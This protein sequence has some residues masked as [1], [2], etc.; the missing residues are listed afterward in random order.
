[1]RV[2]YFA[3]DLSDASVAK[4]IR[5]LRLGG[6]TVSVIG[7]RRT[8]APILEI[9]GIAAVDLG[10][11]FDGRLV[12]RCKMVIHR[13]AWPKALI[14]CISTADVVVARNLEMLTI[15][16]AA[17]RKARSRA[18]LVYECLDV[19]NIML[20]SGLPSRLLRRWESSLLQRAS[21]LVI[22]SEG[23]LNHYFHPMAYQLPQVLVVENKRILPG[24][25]GP[26]PERRR[27]PGQPPWR[28]GWFGILRCATSFQLLLE[29]ATTHPT[30][31]DIELRGRPAQDVQTLIARH[32]PLGNMRFGGPYAPSD[33]EV[34][35]QG[36]DFVWAID[37]YQAGQNSEWLLPNRIYEGSFYNVPAIALRNTE[38]ARWLQRRTAGMNV[39]DPG[40]DL[41]Q[42][43]KTLSTA[44]YDDMQ[45]AVADIPLSDLVHSA[46]ECRALI[47][48]ML[49]A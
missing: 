7:F 29:L 36:C 1:M 32:L 20:G 5:M 44:R 39:A 45:R 48:R 6:A 28:I 9:E 34:I 14:P 43:L 46:D 37:Y 2:T 47:N 31:V 27:R 11:T 13:S 33:L 38:T 23:F 24:I 40:S 22:S 35:Y 3:H 18:S 19:H 8:P 12:A 21:A 42:F 4:R 15:A 25:D 16:Y 30:L 17:H 10:R 26:R 49:G 41:P